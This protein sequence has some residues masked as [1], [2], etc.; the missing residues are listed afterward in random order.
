MDITEQEQQMLELLREWNKS[1][2]YQLQIEIV[3]GVWDIAMKELGTQSAARGTGESFKA[4]WDN[5]TPLRFPG[6]L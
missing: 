5:M 3:D 2:N 4:A 1:K 6:V